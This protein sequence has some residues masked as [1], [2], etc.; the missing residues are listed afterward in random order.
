MSINNLLRDEIEKELSELGK[1]QL[2]TEQYE[3]TVNGVTKLLD[4]VIEMDKID[5]DRRMKID[6]REL[7]HQLKLQQ[8]AEEEKDRKRK[9]FL[10][11]A[12]IVVPTGVTIWGVLKSLKFEETGTVTTI[13]G[14]GLISKLLPKR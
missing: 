7:D 2:G 12:G 3:T 5:S 8:M 13:V 9:N 14:R 10:T 11:A 1:I 4:R 6:E